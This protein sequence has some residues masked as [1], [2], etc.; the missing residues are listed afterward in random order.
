MKILSLILLCVSTLA[1][2]GQVTLTLNLNAAQ[3]DVLL[4]AMTNFNAS[5]LD[6]YT[7]V[8][9]VNWS[10]QNVVRAEAK[11]APLPQPPTPAQLDIQGYFRMRAAQLLDASPGDIR[12]DKLARI[13]TR[14]DAQPM[15]PRQ[16]EALSNFLRTNNVVP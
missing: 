8:T 4:A 9:L 11:L 12:A 16:L 2:H 10:V 14:M 13:R 5:A 3:T 15:T 1:C 6:T 7:N